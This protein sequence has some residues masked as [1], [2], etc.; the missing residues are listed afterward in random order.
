MEWCCRRPEGPLVFLTGGVGS[1]FADRIKLDKDDL[2]ILVYCAVAGAFGGFLGSPI[3][4]AVGA[5]E[6][7]FIHEVNYYRHAIPG[8]LAA[9]FGYGV[10]WTLLH[11]SLMGIYSFPNYASPRVIDL[12][13]ALLIGV[14]AGLIG[15]LYKLVFGI[16]HLIFAPL[17]TRPVVRAIVGG[18]V[19]GLV[20]SFLPLALYSGQDQLQEI[21]KN[22]AA[23]GAGLLLLLL[24]AKALLTSTSY[25]TGFDGGPIFPLLFIGGTMGLAISQVFPFIPQGVGVTTGMADLASAVFPIPLTVA[26][27]LGFL[28]GQIDLTPTITIGAV[29][30]FLTARALAPLLPKPWPAA[31]SH[32]ARTP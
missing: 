25:A 29:I 3:I 22:P 10:Y 20:G 21:I 26:I 18:V 31:G 27:L 23:Y 6:Y 15:T 24:L 17:N 19:I 4:G 28:G 7:M 1:F 5:I 14:F 13:W 11:T 12:V 8:L 30:G 9:S 32:E 16:M 2:S